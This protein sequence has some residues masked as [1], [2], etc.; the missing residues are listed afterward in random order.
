MK[1]RL[2]VWSSERRSYRSSSITPWMMVHWV[3]Y[4]KKTLPMLEALAAQIFLPSRPQPRSTVHNLLSWMKTF[5][6][7]MPSTISWM[8]KFIETMM[9]QRR[10]SALN[11]IIETIELH[12]H[13]RKRSTFVTSYLSKSTWSLGSYMRRQHRRNPNALKVAGLSITS[14]MQ[15]RN[16][17]FQMWYQSVATRRRE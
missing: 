2:L 3:T 6:E 15:T 16:K 17:A 11:T 5:R 12:P 1:P 10:Q 14:Q 9:I 4:L 7:S 8:M 13:L